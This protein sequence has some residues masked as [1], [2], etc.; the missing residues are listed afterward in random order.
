MRSLWLSLAA[1]SLLAVSANAQVRVD[2]GNGG[3][4]VDAPGVRANAAAPTAAAHRGSKLMGLAVKNRDNEDLG[5]IEDLVIDERG[6]VRYAAVSY[7]GFLGFNNKLF[8]VPWKALTLKHDTSNNYW[9]ELNVSK[10]YIESAEGFD[11]EKW[12]TFADPEVN[13]KIDAFYLRDTTNPNNTIK[14]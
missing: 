8:A 13:A 2:V 5:K 6:H 10:K 11:K 3:V 12:P 9:V 14:P 1:V 7:G 4:Q